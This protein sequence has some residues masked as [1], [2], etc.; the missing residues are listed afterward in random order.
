MNSY[1]IRHL[2]SLGISRLVS[3]FYSTIITADGNSEPARPDRDIMNRVDSLFPGSM[4]GMWKRD[5]DVKIGYNA[6]T[7]V[8]KRSFVEGEEVFLFRSFV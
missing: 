4:E 6:W 7:A 1:D 2:L 3:D 8:V 5:F